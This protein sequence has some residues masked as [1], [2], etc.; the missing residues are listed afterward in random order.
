MARS[1]LWLARLGAR[2]E[3]RRVGKGQS[4]RRGNCYALRTM[5]ATLARHARTILPA[6]L[7][8]SSALHA[9][10]LEG[11]FEAA[12]VKA[13]LKDGC[14]GRWDFSASHGTVSAQNA[15]LLRIISRAYN[16][17]D[18]RIAGPAWLDSQCYDITAKAAGDVPELTLMP[19]LQ[20]LLK[21]RFHL[22]VRRE[23]E[24]RPVLALLPDKGGPK[25][26]HY[27]A[28]VPT[29]PAPTDGKV[30]FMARHMPDLCERLGKVA[31]RPVIDKTGL[32]GD[33]L[34]VLTYL[35]FAP[36]NGELAFSAADIF[37]AVREQ[38]G[39][40]LEA[41]RGLVEMIKIDNV[42][43]VPTEN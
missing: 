23:Q 40:R 28:K 8:A 21:E 14:H 26:P 6:I 39:L 15:P 33:Y 37:A 32:K 5:P 10:T 18:D 31:G 41:Q 35:P 11:R 16:L 3:K 19:M 24:E 12:S 13:I 42:D 7:V 43:E 27:G 36:T 17:T 29:P 38:L 20:T 34:I 2:R 25:V 22:A 30:L 1:L 9:Q 4:L